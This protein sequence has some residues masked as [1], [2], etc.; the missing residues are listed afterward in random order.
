[1]P[2]HSNMPAY[3]TRNRASSEHTAATPGIGD[4][5]SFIQCITLHFLKSTYPEA[6][7]SATM[8]QAPLP[9]DTQEMIFVVRKN[10]RNTRTYRLQFTII[11]PVFNEFRLSSAQLT[12]QGSHGKPQPLEAMFFPILRNT[13]DAIKSSKSGIPDTN[14]VSTSFNEELSNKRESENCRSSIIQEAAQRYIDTLR[15]A[16]NKLLKPDNNDQQLF[17]KRLSFFDPNQPAAANEDALRGLVTW[18]NKHLNQ[19][20]QRKRYKKVLGQW[21]SFVKIQTK[22]L[23]DRFNIKR[24]APEE[25]N[26]WISHN[27]L[28]FLLG[29]LAYAP[30]FVMINAEHWYSFKGKFDF[31]TRPDDVPPEGDFMAMLQALCPAQTIEHS[32]KGIV[33]G[34]Q[35]NHP[36][37]RL[38]GAFCQHL[39]EKSPQLETYFQALSHLMTYPEAIHFQCREIL[40]QQELSAQK[41]PRT[42]EEQI[43]QTR[44]A[45]IATVALD[46]QQ[47]HALTQVLSKMPS[48]APLDI[49]QKAKHQEKIMSDPRS[50][51][52]FF[53]YLTQPECKALHSKLATEDR[54]DFMT[55]TEALEKYRR[56]LFGWSLADRRNYLNKCRDT[57]AHYF[58]ASKAFSDLF[59]NELAYLDSA[60]A[61]QKDKGTLWYYAPQTL[62]K[63]QPN[64]SLESLTVPQQLPSSPSQAKSPPSPGLPSTP[65]KQTRNYGYWPPLIVGPILGFLICLTCLK[66][67][68]TMAHFLPAP[69]IAICIMTAC[70]LIL[71]GFVLCV[72]KRSPM[73]ANSV[74]QNSTDRQTAPPQPVMRFEMRKTSDTGPLLP[75]AETRKPEDSLKP[76]VP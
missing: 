46:D 4:L 60:S 40:K 50:F 27:P 70:T 67:E 53:S 14:L 39:K 9:S 62:L 64:Q 26:T 1:M 8:A 23:I 71:F 45:V 37:D 58:D 47:V 54:T 21:E 69:V 44:L 33:V 24:D 20:K 31:S 35:R 56:N 76:T 22:T 65:A 42:R 61:M 32:E 68:P 75:I 57:H 73:P 25:I 72:S 36:L 29:L 52:Y 66:Y 10:G 48:E 19:I 11:S 2:G 13:L 28:C 51:C 3:C 7:I 59:N 30:G 17:N 74:I 63:H 38:T 43:H 18:R 34:N 15:T 5:Y 16:V 55:F 49:A 41:S 6:Q 12:E